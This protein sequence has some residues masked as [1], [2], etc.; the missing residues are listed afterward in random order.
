MTQINMKDN[1]Q[2]EYQCAGDDNYVDW[3][4][5]GDEIQEIMERR[6]S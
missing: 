1:Y 5:T 4:S 2:E 3:F 6:R